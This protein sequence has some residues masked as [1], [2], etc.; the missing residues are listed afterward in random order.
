MKAFALAALLSWPLAALAASPEQAYLAARDAA[1]AKLK[2]DGEVSDAMMKQEKAARADLAK[3]LA[4]IIGP[5]AI[6]GLA[7]KGTANLDTLFEGDVG[8]GMLDGLRYATSDGKQAVVVT[9]T[10][11]LDAWVAG[12][13]QDSKLPASATEALKAETAYTQAIS[14]DAAV[15][16]YAEIPITKP[17]GASFAYA[18]LTATSQDVGPPAPTDIIVALIAGDRAYIV[19]A[20]ATAK[21]TA[22]GA[23]EAIAK[24]L[25]AQADVAYQKYTASEL[26]D[27]AAFNESTRLRESADTEYRRCYGEKAS[28]EPFFAGVLKQAQALVDQ[29][30]AR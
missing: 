20:N 15:S 29:L 16:R 30:P 9:T 3:R 8:F 23:C 1:I 21:I 24:E 7:A 6:K 5:V 18:M 4:K 25:S 14:S 28:S 22:I 10:G 26:K 13:P 17:A 2:T 27:E 11:L 19:S 12:R